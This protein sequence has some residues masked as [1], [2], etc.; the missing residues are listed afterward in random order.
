MG[1][2]AQ[3]GRAR[4]QETRQAL[5]IVRAGDDTGWDLIPVTGGEGCWFRLF[6]CWSV[7]GGFHLAVWLRE[8]SSDEAKVSSLGNQREDR[9]AS[10]KCRG[11]EDATGHAELAEVV[12]GANILGRSHVFILE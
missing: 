9:A 10:P 12:S 4:S 3:V 8:T 1:P 5:V 7:T 6:Q 11:I 2:E